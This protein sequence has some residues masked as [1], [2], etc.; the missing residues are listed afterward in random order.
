MSLQK[1]LT[2]YFDLQKRYLAT[3]DIRKEQPEPAQDTPTPK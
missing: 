2:K 1:A 3:R